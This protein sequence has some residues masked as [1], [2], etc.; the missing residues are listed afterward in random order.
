[1]WFIILSLFLF[2]ILNYDEM[3]LRVHLIRIIGCNTTEQNNLSHVWHVSVWNRQELSWTNMRHS[4]SHFTH[5][6]RYNKTFML[7][8]PLKTP[9]LITP[10]TSSYFFLTIVASFTYLCYFPWVQE[11]YPP[12]LWFLDFWVIFVVFDVGFF[13]VTTNFYRFS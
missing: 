5:G 13:Y 4:C 12:S 3:F 10:P 6:T 7:N 1:M 11:I 8:V 2:L 9:N